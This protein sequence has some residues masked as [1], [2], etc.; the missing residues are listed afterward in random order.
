M[1]G[2]KRTLI[3][4]LSCS[5]S[6]SLLSGCGSSKEKAGEI[7]DSLANS[8]KDF[9]DTISESAKEIGNSVSN[10]A[11][12]IGNNVSGAA[13]TIGENVSQWA[14]S[15]NFQQF[16]SGWDY[17][18]KF[19]S[20]AYSSMV[21]SDYIDEVGAAIET[22]KTH[23]NG[24]MNTARG[25]AQEAGFVAER[26]AADTFNINAA[27][28]KSDNHASVVGSNG[29]GS[30][31][32]ETSW[33]EDYSLKYY[34]NADQSAKQQAQTF[35][36]RY[37][38]YKSDTETSGKIALSPEEWMNKN[39]QFS[40]VNRIYDALY[41]GQKRLIPSDQLDAASQYLKLTAAKQDMSDSTIRQALAP[42]TRETLDNLAD[43]ITAPDG[44]TSQPLT[45]AEARAIT[46]L[47]KEGKFDP[48]EFHIQV[49]E[50]VKPKYIL[51]QAME[52]GVSS[53]LL[54]TVFSIGPDVFS[55]VAEAAKN[56]H[57]NTDDLKKTGIDGLLAASEGFL[58][59]SISSVLVTACKLGKFGNEYLNVQPATIGML[60]VLVID[61][62]KY[63]Y[64]LAKGEI[65]P[66]DYSNL[67]AEEIIV[68]LSGQGMGTLFA[69]LLPMFPFA[70]LIGSMVGS[71]L[72]SVGYELTKEVILEVTDNMGIAAIVPAKVSEGLNVAKD[73]V[74]NLNIIDT[75][76]SFKDSIITTLKDGT[77]KIKPA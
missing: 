67:M 9:G 58:E 60:T 47:A 12:D 40:D 77:L 34:Q 3:I 25:V 54:R 27:L 23:V 2:V 39:T 13:Q 26:W 44:T 71:I 73:T 16:S 72:A 61:A 49:S 45:L 15:I 62:I 36:E 30:V 41:S 7:K 42:A 10:A 74:A 50:L 28:N 46:E 69:I 4:L 76:S 68:A 22:L 75:L 51:S 70:Y 17:A 59:G 38:K 65:T 37:C 55:I 48:A 32:V 52:A 29:L 8:A 57:F 63:G 64:S 11:Q 33:A 31:D 20:S 19:M 43:R 6:A 24:S 53:A 18:V 21:T 1:V 14:S 5:L 35:W 66:L 56:G